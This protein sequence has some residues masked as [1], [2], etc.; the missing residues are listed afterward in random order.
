MGKSNW[1]QCGKKKRYRDEHTVN[2]YRRKYEIK[3]GVKADYYWCSCCKGFHI[4]T[5]EFRPEGYGID[6]SW[7]ES[8]GLQVVG[9]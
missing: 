5:E 7:L 1:N 8:L 4:T 6:M 2:L 9:L 3:Y